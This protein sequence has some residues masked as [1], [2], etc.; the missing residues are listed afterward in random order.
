MSLTV[1]CGALLLHG[2]LGP[3][4]GLAAGQRS[5][6]RSTGA[7]PRF[8]VELSLLGCDDGYGTGKEKPRISRGFCW[9]GLRLPQ[10]SATTFT[11]RRFLAPLVVNSTLP[12][13]SA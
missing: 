8:A 7:L 5:K 11:V 6:L 10:A 9:R 12:S 4:R 3:C 13:T 1:W 2:G